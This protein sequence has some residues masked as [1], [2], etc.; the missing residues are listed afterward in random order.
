ML[1]GNRLNSSLHISQAK[2]FEIL[3]LTASFLKDKPSKWSF[4]INFLSTLIVLTEKYFVQFLQK[5]LI[6]LPLLVFLITFEVVKQLG[7]LYFFI[8]PIEKEIGTLNQVKLA[9]LGANMWTVPQRGRDEKFMVSL[10][11]QV[12]GGSLI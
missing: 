4:K 3:Y 9:F 5:Y 6:D 8:Y 10:S 11:N 2:D 7:H 1:L 12:P